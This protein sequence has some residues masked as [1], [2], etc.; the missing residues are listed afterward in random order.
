MLRIDINESEKRVYINVSGYITK[1]D[2]N[3]FLNN[4]KQTM[5]SKKASLYKLI[6]NPEFFECEDEEDI[7]RVCMTFYKNGFK[8]MYL[9]D[10]ENYIMNNLTLKPLEK[11]LFL[12][13]VKVV[14]TMEATK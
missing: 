12:K 9:V 5:K 7:K 11:K 6:V 8:K 4:Y 10:E 2:A 3:N 13:A 14:S 1:R